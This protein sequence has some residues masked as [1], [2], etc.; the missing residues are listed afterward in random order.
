MPK[1]KVTKAALWKA[2]RNKCKDCCCNS[3]KEIRLCPLTECD[4]HPYRFG[5]P[6]NGDEE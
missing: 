1:V 5:R 2:I 6:L 4:L 3:T